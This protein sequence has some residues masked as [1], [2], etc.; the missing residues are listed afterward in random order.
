MIRRL[1]QRL[2]DWL[3]PVPYRE[4]PLVAGRVVRLMERRMSELEG[5]DVTL[6]D[7]RGYRP[8]ARFRN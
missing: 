5:R 7:P 8:D 1:L 4:P 2:R 6:Y 3:W